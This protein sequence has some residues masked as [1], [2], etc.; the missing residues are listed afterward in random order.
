MPQTRQANNKAVAA[1]QPAPAEGPKLSWLQE[2]LAAA[3][4]A[5]DNQSPTTRAN[6]SG[7]FK[8]GKG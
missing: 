5:I 3:Q 6:L 1:P 7:R 2:S 4:K 8:V